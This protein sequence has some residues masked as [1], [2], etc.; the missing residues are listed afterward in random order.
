MHSSTV[1]VHTYVEIFPDRKLAHLIM[2]HGTIVDIFY[3]INRFRAAPSAQCHRQGQ[4]ISPFAL[5]R[6]RKYNTNRHALPSHLAI[7]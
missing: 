5:A 4:R 2:I 1:E 7:N 6:P 3:R